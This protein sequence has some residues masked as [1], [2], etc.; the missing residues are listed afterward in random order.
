[1]EGLIRLVHTD[2]VVEGTPVAVNINGMPPLAVYRVGSHWFVTDN[3][4]T[5]GNAFLHEGF[6]DQDVIECPFHGGAFSIESGEAIRAPCTIALTTY[7]TIIEEGF[8]C[9]RLP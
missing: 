5:H 3:V 4:C 1:M 6:Q 2:S 9:I 8:V 7:A